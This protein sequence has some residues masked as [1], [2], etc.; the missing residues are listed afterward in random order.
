MRIN[1]SLRDNFF[2]CLMLAIMIVTFGSTAFAQTA[3]KIAGTV[4]DQENG[5]G[6]PGANVTIVGTSLGA[7]TDSEGRYF[8]LNVP[9]GTHTVKA[10]FIGYKAISKQNVPASLGVTTEVNFTL[11]TSVIEGEELVI[12]AEAPL[13]EKTLTASR[14]G[15]GTSEL[16]N[17]LPARS[18][19]DI[20]ETTA[21]TF[22]G[23]IRGGRKY[24]SKTLIDGVN[25][26][27]T[28]FSGGTGG[29]QVIQTYTQARR[30]EGDEFNVVPVNL[31][32]AQEVAVLA[33][34]FAAEYDA[35]TAGVINITTK[36]GGD[37]VSGKVFLR[38]SMGG[39]N[40][41]GPDV[42]NDLDKFLQERQNNL[43][44]GDAAKIQKANL[45]TFNQATINEIG[46][47]S[48]PRI[49]GEISLGGPL[50]SRGNFYVSGRFQN[51]HGRFPGEFN[52]EMTTSLK[53]NYNVT[54]RDKLTGNL[55][56][57][58]GGIL[59]GWKN[60]TFSAR[61]KFFPQGNPQNEKLG[62]VGYLV[63]TKS[64]STSTFFD[65]RGS[66]TGRT[67]RFGYSDD[68]NDGIIDRGEN[69]DFLII[70]TAEQSLK[71]LGDAG[72]GV[73]TDASGNQVR[74]AFSGDPG[75]DAFPEA[76]YPGTNQYRFAQPGFY[77]EELK[78]NALQL[79]G[80]ITSQVTYHHQLKSGFL[81]R[82]HS[83]QDFQQRTQVRVIYDPNFPFEESSYDINPTEFAVYLQDRIEYQGI[84]INAG[85]R[86]D[87][88]DPGA[89]QFGD[90]FNVSQQ[91]TLASGRIVRREARTANV[92]TK[93]FFGPRIG[94]SHPISDNAA[95]HYSWGRFFSPPPFA[96][97]FDNYGF[98]SNP[99]LPQLRDVALK[100][101]E[102][103]AYEI[104]LQW[105]FITD[106][107]LNATAYYRDIK[108]YSTAGYAINPAAG[109]GFGSY[110]YL[111]SFG[112]ADARGLEISLQRRPLGWL[113]GR[114][115]YAYSYIKAARN[116]SNISSNK[117]SFSAAA[118]DEIPFEDRNQWNTYSAN[119]N[120]GG[121]PL[122][123]GY[124][125]EHRLALT[126]LI[127]LPYD[128]DI[129]GISTAESGFWYDVTATS[130]DPREREQKRSPWSYRTD[131]RISKGFNLGGSRFGRIFLEGRNI[132]NTE[133]IL[134]WDNYNIASTA[135]W[136]E[137]GD[138]TGD[139][140]RATQ[141]SGLPIY[142][143]AREFYAGI[144]FSF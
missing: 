62:L 35:A 16:N 115:S 56:L 116:A 12:T 90:F 112:Y 122:E 49:D 60:R 63:W 65:V 61:Y 46:Y 83:V 42:Y 45:M 67:S 106:Y 55:I 124:D 142:D 87:A 114:V 64:L 31:Q 80:D 40:H 48:D 13:V 92:P 15:I 58:D 136:E 95:M 24:E 125:R 37:K 8:I 9:P 113:S 107:L 1:P 84:I 111:T 108:N 89:K 19:E 54:T 71:Y 93:W 29:N 39:L 75:N 96:A 11:E 133:N 30:S 21:S 126:F 99:S 140:N 129:T 72:S 25:I 78:R 102:S 110:T 2:W 141:L 101:P 47:G 22:R 76:Q 14:T 98:I 127:D 91:D 77:Y 38:S 27:D 23:F 6:L 10:T 7:S 117:N 41:A 32:S 4:I 26:S 5:E 103:T 100:P 51:D 73:R 139:L 79:K 57:N 132:F 118:D 82:R 3:G 144:D 104:G 52:R 69:G 53:L 81:F 123:S 20:V 134:T 143:I 97:L 34:T 120:G 44:S 68:N 131:L 135:L 59:G 28:Y 138:P 17:T 130:T 121:N 66:Y 105:E 88:F 18:L 36:D 94:I 43:D 86:I 74:T 50:S 128:V 70:K 119:V 85:V 33:G 109:Q 137:E